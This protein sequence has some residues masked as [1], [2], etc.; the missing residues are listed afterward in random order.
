MNP[1]T[2]EKETHGHRTDLGLPRGRGLREG[3][4]GSLEL[5]DANCYGQDG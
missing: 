3:R 1:S 2:K 5:A 4:T